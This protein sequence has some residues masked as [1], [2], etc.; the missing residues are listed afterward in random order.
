MGTPGE[1]DSQAQCHNCEAHWN[2]IESC[3][4]NM[5]HQFLYIVAHSNVDVNVIWNHSDE[6]ICNEK[7]AYQSA[8]QYSH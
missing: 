7:T 6:I 8:H 2:I 1:Q 5:D 3:C 4:D